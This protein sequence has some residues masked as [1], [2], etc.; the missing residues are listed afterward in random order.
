MKFL[1]LLLQS[2]TLLPILIDGSVEFG[3]KLVELV[4]SEI[5]RSLRVEKLVI[6]IGLL[7]ETLQGDPVI[8]KA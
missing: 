2:G 4:K 6:A 3:L 5:L 7:C 8:A 1:Y